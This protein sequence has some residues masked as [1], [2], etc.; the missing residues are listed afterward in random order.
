MYYDYLLG[1]GSSTTVAFVAVALSGSRA[2]LTDERG[3]CLWMADLTVV[4]TS[5]RSGDAGNVV[6]GEGD[7]GTDSGAMRGSHMP[8]TSKFHKV[9]VSFTP[10]EHFGLHELHGIAIDER[11]S[12]AYV[13]DTHLRCV[14]CFTFSSP[15]AAVVT[16]LCSFS[17]DALFRPTDRPRG[18]ALHRG[19]FLI[20]A[21][22]DKLV[23][24][25]LSGAQRGLYQ[26]VHT[27]KAPSNTGIAPVDEAYEHEQAL[28]FTFFCGVAVC[29]ND[30]VARVTSDAGVHALWEFRIPKLSIGDRS[31][32]WEGKILAGGN[33]CFEAGIQGQ[34]GT[35][36]AVQ[37][38]RPSFC[39]FALESLVLV[40]TGAASVMLMTNLRPLAE[41]LLPNMRKLAEAGGLCESDNA[42][43]MIESYGRLRAVDDMFTSVQS[44]NT[45]VIGRP[46][47]Q[48]NEGCFSRNLR[49][50][51]KT[52][53]VS[54]ERKFL[55]WRNR[56]VPDA[57]V[58][59]F[60]LNSTLT[61]PVECFFSKLRGAQNSGGCNPYALDCARFRAGSI[62]EEAKAKS[63]LGY[64]YYTGPSVHYIAPTSSPV[65]QVHSRPKKVVKTAG[66]LL[67][68]SERRAKLAILRRCA[69][70][71]RGP[72][73]GRVTDKA[74]HQPGTG[75]TSL[76]A[77]FMSAPDPVRGALPLLPREFNA[78]ECA[79]PG[80]S[81][82][83]H[84]AGT[85]IIVKIVHAGQECPFQLVELRENLIEH[86]V[87]S[88]KKRD[89]HHH[90]IK[91][92]W[93]SE[94]WSPL[95]ADFHQDEND[96]YRFMTSSP[97]QLRRLNASSFY[98]GIDD[99]FDAV[100]SE[101]ELTA[102]SITEETY[103][104]AVSSVCALPG[105]TSA[106]DT[107]PDESE[108]SES[109]TGSNSDGNEL[110]ARETVVR[111]ARAGRDMPRRAGR[112]DLAAL[113][114]IGR[115]DRR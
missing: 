81:R 26:I 93:K 73:S 113:G 43:N 61:I 28:A 58:R 51:I 110:P 82:V 91:Y 106:P 104:T 18:I 20:V 76:R 99:Y 111:E 115:R 103:E 24:V 75:P 11:R 112:F 83:L 33:T 22:A 105:R 59:A 78:A 97:I 48:G 107:P 8:V 71:F 27:A 39:C 34:E 89:R 19:M 56:K 85:I 42:S 60:N 102:F 17:G 1:K 31:P 66:S 13:T 16:R 72:R 6:Q 92:I 55:E 67:E 35:A 32:Q 41:Y 69:K 38:Y 57:L 88:T 7:D 45:L 12:V 23:L 21:V 47:G 44:A 94:N 62:N 65:A 100:Q 10:M 52:M 15:T 36:S 37:L 80:I 90:G 68:P 63:E 96:A 25:H 87:I 64:S 109:D 53:C 101:G 54:L 50:S 9:A 29:A 5:N 40:H 2:Y 77:G 98:G 79:T 14:Y 3:G 4:L 30:E 86:K 49:R 84:F 114:L 46:S 108:E 95:V 70:Y 74:K